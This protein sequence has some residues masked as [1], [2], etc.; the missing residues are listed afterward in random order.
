MTPLTNNYHG[1]VVPGD[2]VDF[3][4]NSI[5][6]FYHFSNSSIITAL[7]PGKWSIV[8]TVSFKNGHA[9][10]FDPRRLEMTRDGVISLLARKRLYWVNPL[11]EKEPICL[12]GVSPNLCEVI[13]QDYG[14]IPATQFLP[15]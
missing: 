4:V 3:S 7:P 1:I 12:N 15:P 13:A 2:A 14:H 6:L 5:N 8:G 11:G 10:D 9:M